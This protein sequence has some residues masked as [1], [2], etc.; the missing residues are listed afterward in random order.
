MKSVMSPG[1]Q[2]G[3]GISVTGGLPW[4]M[5]KG[6]WRE[7]TGPVVMGFLGHANELI[8]YSVSRGNR[9]RFFFGKEVI[10]LVL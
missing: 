5:L 3:S 10:R 2:Y 6:R 8:F 1:P 9:E 7:C 4:R